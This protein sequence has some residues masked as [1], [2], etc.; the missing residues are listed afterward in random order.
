MMTNRDFVRLDLDTAERIWDLIIALENEMWTLAEDLFTKQ[1]EL[2]GIVE[3]MESH[4]SYSTIPDDI[5][6]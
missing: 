4:E 1:A 5:P 6:Y 3:E 2:N